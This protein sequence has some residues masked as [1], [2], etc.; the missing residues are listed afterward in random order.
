MTRTVTSDFRISTCC[1]ELFKKQEIYS[2]SRSRLLLHFVK[3]SIS[4]LQSTSKRNCLVKTPGGWHHA[5]RFDAGKKPRNMRRKLP[6][7]V[8]RLLLPA[9]STLM[10]NAA[11][12]FRS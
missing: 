1:N 6:P 5:S 10:T 9:R 2:E 7:S 8:S 4:A 11:E 12:S 3:T